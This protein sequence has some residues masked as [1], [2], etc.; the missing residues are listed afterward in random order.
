[1]KIAYLILAH[2]NPLLLRRAIAA[3][4]FGDA[5][6]FI[7][8]DA[9]SDILPF[10]AINAQNVVFLEERIKVYWGEFSQVR[11]ILA[12]ISAAINRPKTY[13]Y[14]ILLGG[15]DYPLQTKEY[16]HKFLDVHRGVEFID[17]VKIP[18]LPAGRPISL[19]TRFCAESS[20]PLRRL[21]AKALCRA[22]ILERDYRK[23]L[24]GIEPYG[25]ETWW[26]L[27]RDACQYISEF[28]R[29]QPGIVKFFTNTEVPD[30]TFIHTIIGNSPFAK[31][32]RRNL[33]YRDWSAGGAHPAMIGDSHVE[34]FGANDR[35]ILTDAFGSGEVLFARK[36]SDGS[37]DLVDKIDAMIAGKD[38]RLLCPRIP[39]KS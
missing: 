28:V 20:T 7:H 24:H 23:H 6:F 10:L 27:T 34:Q 14:F 25:G 33:L 1:M 18:N 26:A 3:L 11:A 31:R 36:F 30:E 8:I 13:D 35:V 38:Q 32:T 9:K 19:M 21:A 2:K 22:G 12:L 29:T 37:L 17:M 15:S 16:I 39:V 4:S 5:D